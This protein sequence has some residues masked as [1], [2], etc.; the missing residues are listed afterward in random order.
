MIA[1]A[2][3]R[4]HPIDIL[5]V[6]DNLGDIE[7][8]CEAFQDAKISHRIHIA[9]DGEEALQFLYRRGVYTEAV[10][11][12]LILLD[13][14]MPRRGGKDVL[15]VIK[16]D[17]ELKRIPVIMLTSSEA[18]DDIAKSYSLHANA[19]IVKPMELQQFLKVIEAIE[20]FW[21]TIAKLPQG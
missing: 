18:E 21:L 3:T 7:L 19:Y 14:N 9:R 13:L 6:E 5:L 15:A 11:P 10:R 12:D 8:T 1:P 16:A 4:T 17:D 20:I 2:F